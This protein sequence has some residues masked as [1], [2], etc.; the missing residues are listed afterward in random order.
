MSNSEFV[1]TAND[2]RSGE[3]VYLDPQGAWCACLDDGRVVEAADLDAVLTLGG[4]GEVEGQV[5]GVYEIS[6][7]RD[8]ARIV[9]ERLRERIRAF[10]PS[11][12][13]DFAR[14]EAPEHLRHPDGV[15]AV[16]FNTL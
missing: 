3:V 15:E 6:V 12:H 2:L 4:Q 14:V 8:G 9:P 13:A 11:T 7:S 16:R 10:G 5:V 1:I